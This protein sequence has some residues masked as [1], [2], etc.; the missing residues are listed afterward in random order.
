MDETSINLLNTVARVTRNVTSVLDLGLLLRRT[1]DVIC[2]EFGFEHAAVFLI[3][4]EGQN[5]V[6]RAGRGQING[7]TMDQAAQLSLDD[8][9]FVCKA[10]RRRQA[11]IAPGAGWE[12]ASAK[13]RLSALESRVA[14]PLDVAGD[15]IGALA[16]QSEKLRDFGQ[17]DLITLQVVADQLAIAINNS[18][19]HSQIRELLYQSVRRARLLGAAN[20]VGHSVASILDL[21]QLLPKTVDTIC[22][23]YGFYYTGVFLIDESGEWAVLRAG[24]GEAGRAMIAAEHKL[25]VEGQSMIGAAIRQ[26]EARIALDVGEEAA[27]FKNPHLPQTRSEIALPLIVGDKVLG[28]VT[29]QSAKERAFGSDDVTTLQAMADYLAIAIHNAQTVEELESAHAELL[30][31][32]TYEAIATATGEAIHWVGN[33]AAPIPASVMRVTEDVTQ[34]L[35]MATGLLNEAP[36]DLRQHK[37]AQLLQ[38]ASQ[39]IAA[40]GVDLT[41]IQARLAR[42]PLVRLRRMLNIESIFEDLNIIQAGADAILNIKEDLMGPAR[43]RTVELVALPELLTNVVASM[44]IPSGVVNLAFTDN[45]PPVRADRTQLDRVFINLVKNAMEAM[46]TVRDKKLFIWARLSNEPG[47]V[48]VEIID[49]GVGIPP[50]EID[51][52]WVAFYTTKGDRG[53]TGLGLSAC[54][55]IIQQSGGKVRVDSQVG[56]GTTFTVLLPVAE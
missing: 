19:L 51:K 2:G 49:N 21:D 56:D 8:D 17:A 3:D 9:S 27:F 29:V 23:T 18:R 43:K 39:D 52:I 22:E 36:P 20:A 25:R 38:E 15:V 12:A 34:Y 30:R 7:V 5:A 4:D 45:L 48:A 35:S 33:K 53:G 46:E 26:R 42:Q 13:P 41:Q 1:I 14:L 55:E 24:R 54:L 50:E 32:K 11:Q 44:G 31:N 47:M 37:F 28:A 6:L 16:V 10:I 40:Q